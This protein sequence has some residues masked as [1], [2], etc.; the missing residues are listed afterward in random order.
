MSRLW[1]RVPVLVLA[2]ALVSLSGSPTS[3][4]QEA[5][6]TMEGPPEGIT[7]EAVTGGRA[8]A[9]PPAPVRIEVHRVTFASGISF[10]IPPGPGVDLVTIESGEMTY[11]VTQPVTVARGA[12]AVTTQAGAV[13][14]PGAQEMIPANTEFVLH[15]GDAF[16]G[17]PGAG[18]DLHNAGPEPAVALVVSIYTDESGPAATATP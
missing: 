10:T 7:I 3:F 12:G 5:T 14:T 2:F 6:P 13:G 1:L 9:L 11:R 16:V 15:P 8:E 18:A 4:A 17:P